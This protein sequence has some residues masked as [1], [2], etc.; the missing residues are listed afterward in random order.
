MGEFTILAKA[1]Q[2]YNADCRVARW[3]KIR[4]VKKAAA[5]RWAEAATTSG[6]ML[7]LREHGEANTFDLDDPNHPWAKIHDTH[8]ACVL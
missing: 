8:E 7:R 5:Q 1:M 2:D 4:L 3:A 6:A